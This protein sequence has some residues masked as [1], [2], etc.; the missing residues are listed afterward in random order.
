MKPTKIILSAILALGA[1]SMFAQTGAQD[2]SRF[3][4]GEDSI[5]CIKNISLY[6]PYAKQKQFKDA[7]DYWE[8]AYA[9]CPAASKNLYI[10]G[11]QIIEWQ[12]KNENDPAKKKAL[13]DKLMGL[14]DNRI[15]YFGNDPKM[16]AA[17]ILGNKAVDYLLY[18]GDAADKAV[19]YKWLTEAVN[20]AKDKSSATMIKDWVSTSNAIFKADPETRE[21]Y[22]N[23]YMQGIQYLD[24]QLKT[25]NEKMAPYID[26]VKALLNQQ[27]ALS[28]A[29]D[30]DALQNM[31]AS[32]IEEKK[33]DKEFLKNTI[34]LLRRAKCQ[35]SEVYFAA[36]NYA[37]QIE[38]TMESAVGMAKQAVKKDDIAQ[39][40]TYFEEAAGM[41]TDD[42]DKAE[43]Y[44]NMASLNYKLKKYQM[45]RANA[46]KS[47]ESQPNQGTPY[48]LIASMYAGDARN[49]YPNDPIM[50]QAVFYAAV[51]KLEKAKQVDPSMAAEINS[52]I[53]SYRS[54]FPKNEDV[55]MHQDLEKGKT[56]TIGGWIQEKTVVR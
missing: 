20:D 31:Y 23:D 11:V 46:L 56:I 53:A 34:A 2:G 4:K 12:L 48:I 47:L 22:I 28:G 45:A 7:L 27:F 49:I 21:T 15:K 37:H 33:D 36:S 10:Y 30:C 19:A 43:I 18:M 24:E 51:D 38:P 1:S 9:E 42:A 13:V 50:A 17:K 14:Y 54:Y 41:A 29:A 3:G 6:E 26:Q 39:A 40:I 44:L 25:A 5:R 16:P 55:F 35:E 8:L 52:Q 32:K